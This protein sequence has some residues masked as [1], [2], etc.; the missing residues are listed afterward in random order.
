MSQQASHTDRD[1][2]RGALRDLISLSTECAATESDIEREYRTSHD[3]ENHAFSDHS[4]A[5][6]NRHKQLTEE[7]NQKHRDRLAELD[8][9]YKAERGKIDAADRALRDK[10]EGEKQSADDKLKQKYDQAVWLADSVHELGTNQAVASFKQLSEQVKGANETLNG[11]EVKAAELV[12]RYGLPLPADDVEAEDDP[13]ILTDTDAAF[14][15]HKQALEGYL[16]QLH[17][18]PVANLFVGARPYLIPI[19]LTILAV[20]G[21]QLYYQST[22][23]QWKPLGIFAGGVIGLQI[24]AGIVLRLMANAQV[25]AVHTPLRKELVLARRAAEQ[26]MVNGAKK[27]DADLAAA[28]KA[29]NSEIQAAKEVIGPLAAKA[30]RLRDAGIT[31]A[32]AEHSKQ[33]TRID[34]IREA[35][36]GEA[37]EK[38]RRQINEIDHRLERE[39]KENKIRHEARLKE[40]EQRQT[41]R[42]QELEARWSSGL[43]EIQAPIDRDGGASPASLNWIDPAWKAWI[44]P[45]KFAS[46][47]RFGEMQ[48]DLKTIAENFPRRLN[49]PETFSLPALLAFPAQASLLIH[50]DHAGRGVAIRT[51]QMLMA[52]LLTSLPAGRVRFT[53][54]DP[55]GLG[56]NFAGFMHLA[57]YDDALVGGRIWTSQDQIDQRLANLTDHMETVIQKYLRNEFETIDDYNA[58]AGELAEPYRFL[59]IADLP[60]GFTADAFRRLN[61]IASSGARCGVYTLIARDTR[62]A[63]PAGRISMNLRRTA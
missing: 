34:K 63:L 39:I 8:G 19:L 31:M 23:P 33:I 24:I 52:R 10:V 18:M 47:V 53:I 5:I 32:Q 54:I 45:R 25:R 9:Q 43:K 41:Q 56:Q 3:K 27:R 15:R 22:E 61:S 37:G 29:R 13:S 36:N 57:D 11:M 46:R 14:G 6:E 51:L 44:P 42:K 30:A 2:Q 55:V 1:I 20:A 48:V 60:V 40:I 4:F 59:V 50:T 28:T 12:Q 17:S 49:L 21:V 16:A 62:A 35:A 26:Q 58:Q 38:Y 7:A